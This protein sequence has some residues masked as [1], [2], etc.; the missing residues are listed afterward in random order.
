[1]VTVG[2]PADIVRP[3]VL[4]ELRIPPGLASVTSARHVIRAT[5]ELWCPD[6]AK[7]AELVGCELITNAIR[8]ATG[9]GDRQIR[10]QIQRYPRH[11]RLAV[12]DGSP[13]PPVMVRPDELAESGRGLIMISMLCEWG[14]FP[15]YLGKCV[16]ARFDLDGHSRTCRR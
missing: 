6:L 2:A 8:H 15:T 1:M 9:R 7:D 10:A 16:W 3:V 5:V 11:L 12:Y 13:V 14:W 4:G